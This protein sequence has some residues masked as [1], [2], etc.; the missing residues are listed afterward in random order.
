MNCPVCQFADHEKKRDLY[1]DRYGY[2]GV[3]SLLRCLACGHHFLDASFSNDEINNLY[4]NFY[5]R[6]EFVLDD[7]K[8]APAV[9]GFNA[10]LNGERRSAY[11]WVPENVCVLDIGC[12]WGETLA[13]HQLRGCEAHGVEV[14]DN[15][16][17]V[18]ELY[19]LKIKIGLFDSTLY[20][21][22]YF[23][24]VTMDQ[25]IEHVVFPIQT[26][27]DIRKV[28]KN[29]GVLIL[30]T[31]NA[32]GWGTTFFGR[33]WINWH[34]PYHLNLFTEHSMR[35]AAHQA[36]FEVNKIKT[37][38]SSD[39]LYFQ[40]AHL[41][42]Y[43][44]PNTPSIYWS[45]GNASRWGWLQILIRRF[46]KVLHRIKLTHVITRFF[47]GIGRGDGMLIFLRKV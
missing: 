23:D 43:P 27:K 3:F 38:T 22:N 45:P 15:V 7:L 13:Y 24:Y 6:S 11:C 44:K 29:N 17:T 31:P 37:L 8:P 32:N 28:L 25:V 35:L 34:T 41:I 33:K 1:D 10:W 26:L 39:W 14:D 30:N 40:F 12:G 21:E 42:T 47:D 18:A 5:P 2:P 4:T 9:H 16:K 19:G 46:F 36:G 20:E